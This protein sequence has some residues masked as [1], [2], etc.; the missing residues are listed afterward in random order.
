MNPKVDAY[1]ENGCGRCKYFAT[2][3]CKINDWR[4]ELKQLRRIVLDCGLTEELK[5]GVACY[6]FQNKNLVLLSAYKAYASLAF[7]KGALLKDEQ[8]ILVSPGENS[9]AVRQLR[10]TDVAKV[11]TQESIIKSYIFEAI[12]VEKAG[13]QILKKKTTHLDV[14]EEL[15][16]KFEQMPALKTAFESLTPGRQ[17]GYL[18]Y[19]TA[20]KQSKTRVSRIEKLVPKILAGKGMHD[21]YAD[22]AF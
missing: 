15:K 7:F 19:F 1:L 9:Q 12:E 14:P 5:W 4:D 17:R 3:Q 10:Y 13:L 8:N 6:T 21:E 16:S 20:A 18:L 11:T 22:K 2:P